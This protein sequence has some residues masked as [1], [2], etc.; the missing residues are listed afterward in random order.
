MRNERVEIHLTEVEKSAV[1]QAAE[2]TGTP[3]AVFVRRAVLN[4]ARDEIIRD[5][6]FKAVVAARA[7]GNRDAND[8]SEG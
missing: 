7:F 8:E 1:Q 3:T 2:L 5:L 4:E 6:G